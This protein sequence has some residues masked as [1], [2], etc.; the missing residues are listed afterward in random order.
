ME[1]VFSSAVL[2]QIL[3]CLAVPAPLSILHPASASS[4]DTTAMSPA[5][6]QLSVFSASE[7]FCNIPFSP[8]AALVKFSPVNRENTR[9]MLMTALSVRFHV[10]I[11][12]PPLKIRLTLS[13]ILSQ[14][15]QLFAKET[16]G[17]PLFQ[18][19]T[20]CG[21]DTLLYAPFAI[22]AIACSHL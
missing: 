8:A 1:N 16:S 6:V 2:F 12:L 15:S 11:S 22:S 21:N 17:G 13:V 19:L 7:P 3:K 9:Q 18:Q 4:P 5:I 20:H 14:W 10:F